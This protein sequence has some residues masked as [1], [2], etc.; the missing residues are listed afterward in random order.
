MVRWAY[1]PL[2]LFISVAYDI[3]ICIRIPRSKV[4][5]SCVTAALI[6]RQKHSACQIIADEGPGQKEEEKGR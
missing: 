3:H 1:I 2:V 6:C 5:H 4:L